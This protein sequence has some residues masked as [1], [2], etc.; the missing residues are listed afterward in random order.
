MLHH[1]QYNHPKLFLTLL[2][3]FGSLRQGHQQVLIEMLK[4]LNF[5]LFVILLGEKLLLSGLWC[6][7]K[8][9]WNCHAKLL[10]HLNHLILYHGLPAHTQTVP[11][12]G[13][14]NKSTVG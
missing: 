11:L 7:T 10:Q 4:K 9:M 14:I 13:V 8:E 6:C 2:P 1:H 12:T 5:F 3:S